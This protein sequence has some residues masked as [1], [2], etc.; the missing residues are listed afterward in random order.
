MFGLSVHDYFTTY[1]TLICT[2]QYMLLS[3]ELTVYNLLLLLLL[4][5][6]KLYF[7]TLYLDMYDS[8]VEF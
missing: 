5:R 1:T 4:I 6:C 3:T 2:D 8:K 7:V